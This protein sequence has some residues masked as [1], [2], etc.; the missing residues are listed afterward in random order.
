MSALPAQSGH[1]PARS[2]CPLSANKRHGRGDCQRK[3]LRIVRLV[4]NSNWVGWSGE[5]VL[6]YHCLLTGC[7][8]TGGFVGPVLP[9]PGPFLTAAPAPFFPHVQV[10]QT[11]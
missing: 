11:S 6:S 3:R 4:T 2:P 1:S 7:G 10:Q 5:K 9:P 8:G